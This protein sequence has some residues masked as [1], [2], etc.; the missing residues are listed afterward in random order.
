[1]S[2]DAG[3]V[4]AMFLTKYNEFCEELKTAYPEGV[5]VIALAQALT[6]AEKKERFI[7][8]VVPKITA[9]KRNP[10]HN[11]GCVL[12]GVIIADDKWF[13]F[14]VNTRKAIQEH[15]TILTFCATFGAEGMNMKWAEEAL[16][17]M[18]EKLN[19]ADFKSFS[20]KIVELMKSGEFYS[21]PERLMK[22]QIAKLAEELVKEFRP[23]DFGLSAEEL[24]RAGND[25]TQAFGLLSQIYTRNPANLQNVMKRIAKRLQEKVQRGELRPQEIASEA[26]E[27]IK[28]FTENPAM[29][30]LMESFKSMFGFE[31]PEAARAVGRDGNSRLAI[32]RNRLRKRMNEKKS[33]K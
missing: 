31:D 15:L 18:K 9:P 13:E 27:L 10:K 6:D 2:V 20:D 4:E 33:G 17:Q 1:M 11:P 26:E 21:I 29:K 25:P 7:K 24:E 16:N 8:Y 22:G 19:S 28:E 30:D 32:A 5:P 14:S 3:N 23:E 12:P